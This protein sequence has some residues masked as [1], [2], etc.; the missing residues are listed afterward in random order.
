MNDDTPTAIARNIDDYN[1]IIEDIS[2]KQETT[3]FRGQSNA[4]HRLLPSLFREYRVVGDEHKFRNGTFR[5]KS[6]AIMKDDL[7]ILEKFKLYYDRIAQTQDFT[8]IDYLYIMQHYEMPTRLLDFSTDP[9]TALY[10]SV[11]KPINSTLDTDHEIQAFHDGFTF[12]DH[13]STVF[14]IDPQWTNK[15][16]LGESR[17]LDAKTYTTQFLRRLDLP[18][19]ITSPNENERIKAQKGVFVLFGSWYNPLD[20]YSILRPKTHKIFI[21]NSCRKK[22]LHELNTKYGISHSTIFPDIKG[23]MLQITED[24]EM[25]YQDNCAKIFNEEPI[26]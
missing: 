18:L 6:D 2:K 23:I 13:G 10:F 7:F 22:I 26:I 11:S 14:C 21:P 16:T 20:Y 15:Q 19:C 5:K 24:I 25:H 9:L 17:I 3:W 4:R 8:M 12:T 1:A